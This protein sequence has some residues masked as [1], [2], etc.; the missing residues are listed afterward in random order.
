MK[1]PTTATE[2]VVPQTTLAELPRIEDVMGE[3][4]RDLRKILH[5]AVLEV[6]AEVLFKVLIKLN[7]ENVIHMEP[8]LDEGNQYKIWSSLRYEADSAAQRYDVAQG[9]GASVMH[10][11]AHCIWIWAA[12]W[13]NWGWGRWW[14]V[15]TGRVPPPSV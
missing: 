9:R 5:D 7:T 3:T 1:L 12:H 10:S 13:W 14:W 2:L 4:N 6:T 15:L 8:A 11:Q